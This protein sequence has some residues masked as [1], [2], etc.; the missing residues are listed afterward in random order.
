VV[1]IHPTAHVSPRA[2]LGK[3][4]SVGPYSIVEAGAIVED[5]CA[6]AAR[7]SVKEYTQLGPD[8][9]VSE[10]AILG[11]WPQHLR[12]GKQVGRVR[13]G[14]GNIIREFVTVHR[15][16]LEEDWTVVGDENLFMAGAHVAHDCHVGNRTIVANNVLLA[17]HVTVEDRAYLSGAV[18]IHQF[19]RIGGYAMVGGQ[20]HITR[21]V[22]PYV[23]VDGESSRVVGLNLVGLRRGGLSS[24]DISRIK[25]AYR[26]IYRS[27][28]PWAEILATLAG[29]F[30]TGPAASFAEF[31]AS[32]RRG[33]VPERRKSS[34]ALRFSGSRDEDDASDADRLAG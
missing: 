21:D 12:A 17:G 9:Q 19:C 29:Q 23:T 3:D 6:L 18:A 4:V 22:P 13:I 10:G 31:L 5:R 1:T 33:I 28:R 20:S 16:L 15:A 7:V 26:L 11:G 30:T 14:R 34:G 25:E 24:E 32:S 8:N 27:G 2:F